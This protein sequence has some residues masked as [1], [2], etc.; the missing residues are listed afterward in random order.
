VELLYCAAPFN[1]WIRTHSPSAGTA[2]G[3]P[4]A[5]LTVAGGALAAAGAGA[6]VPAASAPFPS[7]TDIQCGLIS[8]LSS[9]FTK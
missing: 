2:S 3:V 4:G 6:I 7:G 5:A 9:L 1:E 8:K